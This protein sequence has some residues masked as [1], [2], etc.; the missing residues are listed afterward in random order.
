MSKA[1]SKALTTLRQKLK[2]YNKD[3]E[4]DLNAYRSEPDPLGYSSGAAEDDEEE[5][6][7]YCLRNG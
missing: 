2:K 7:F 5:V 3:F 1:N 6:Y 4:T